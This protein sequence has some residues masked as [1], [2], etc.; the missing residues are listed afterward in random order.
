VDD[1]KA[2]RVTVVPAGYEVEHVEPQLMP[3]G[4]LV[5]VPDPVPDFETESE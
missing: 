3:D 4:E 5:I 1:G 2:V